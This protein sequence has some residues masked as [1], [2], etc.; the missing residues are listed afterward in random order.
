MVTSTKKERQ[1]R[2][3]QLRDKVKKTHLSYHKYPEERR[4]SQSLKQEKIKES[5]NKTLLN[6]IDPQKDQ[7]S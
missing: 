1:Q 6:W 4:R 5:I 3:G 7:F 2:L